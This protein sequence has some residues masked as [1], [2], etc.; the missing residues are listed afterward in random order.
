MRILLYTGKGGAGKTTVAAATAVRCAEGNKRTLIVA[1]DA[2]QSLA[3]CLNSPLTDE[4]SELAPNLWAQEIDPLVRLERVWP[5]V[6]PL[7]CQSFGANLN[8]TA[9]EQLTLAP[10]LGDVI[11]LLALQQHCED[12]AYDVM[13]VDAGASL[14]ALQMLG[15]PESTAWWL[16]RLFGTATQPAAL[17]LADKATRLAD[18]L[19]SLRAT[20]GDGAEC[21]V[22]VVMSP[23][24]LALRESQRAL[25]FANLY[26][27]NVDA[28]IL[29]RQKRVPRSIAET[30]GA[31]PILCVTMYDR[32]VVGYKLL[33]EMALAIFP[34]PMDPADVLMT[35]QAER[36]SRDGDGYL[37]SIKL[38]FIHED[39]IDL[40]QHHGELILQ[41]GRMRRVLQLPPALEG[42]QAADAVLE[43]GTLEIHFR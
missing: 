38:P 41:V 37:L 9:L 34:P 20:L 28:I 8:G 16:N 36:M 10:G 14:S 11:R 2:S 17:E 15:Q 35:G 31:W 27:Y 4:P 22:R 42:L 3:D 23:E 43:E 21:S 39:D 12:N 7:L 1:T 32:D 33:G 19:R 24:Q 18:S 26:G 5:I 6:E 13:V 25:T 40:L 29:N 30:F